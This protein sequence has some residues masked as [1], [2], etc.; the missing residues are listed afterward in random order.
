MNRL[1]TKI[2][3]E[4]ANNE[5]ISNVSNLVTFSWYQTAYQ[6][7]NVHTAYIGK[8]FLILH[9]REKADEQFLIQFF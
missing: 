2:V 6:V 4:I 7:Y 3:T 8:H 5:N 1:I 9:H